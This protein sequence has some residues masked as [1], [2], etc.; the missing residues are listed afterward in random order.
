MEVIFNPCGEFWWSADGSVSQIHSLHLHV[1]ALGM[2]SGV[3]RSV[4]MRVGCESNRKL[5]HLFLPCKT[6]TLL[7]QFAVEDLPLDKSATLVPGFS[8]KDLPYY[9]LYFFTL[10]AYLQLIHFKLFVNANNS[11]IIKFLKRKLFLGAPR[12][13][14]WVVNKADPSRLW[15]KREISRSLVSQS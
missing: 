14:S 8:V 13:F 7:P 4:Q 15:M 10:K 9:R 11:M 6:E 3:L 5:P 1:G 2:F 12:N